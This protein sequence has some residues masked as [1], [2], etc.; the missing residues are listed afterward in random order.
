MKCSEEY[1]KSKSKTQKKNTKK[2]AEQTQTSTNFRG[3]IRCQGGVESS[4]D[5]SRPNLINLNI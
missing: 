1:S 2:G 5:R 3:M 4:A